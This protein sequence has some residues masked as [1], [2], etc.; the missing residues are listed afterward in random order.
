M[1]AACPQFTA[2]AVDLL[3]WLRE[4]QEQL[5]GGAAQKARSQKAL[6]ECFAVE[7]EARMQDLRHLE[8]LGRQARRRASAVRPLVTNPL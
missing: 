6:L 7:Y 4:K 3:D 2:D 8:A 5:A 1:P